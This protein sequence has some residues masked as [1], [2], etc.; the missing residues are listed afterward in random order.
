MSTT[1]SP[2]IAGSIGGVP[3]TSLISAADA[4]NRVGAVRL[5]S[6][7]D[8]IDLQNTALTTL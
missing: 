3:I 4:A 2:S 1:S 8:T 6:Q 7:I 5:Q